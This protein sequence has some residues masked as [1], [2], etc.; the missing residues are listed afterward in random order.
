[1]DV[2]KIIAELYE[3]RRRLDESIVA[4]ERLARKQHRF[5]RLIVPSVPFRSACE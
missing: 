4:I 5:R 2:H 3:E 1:M